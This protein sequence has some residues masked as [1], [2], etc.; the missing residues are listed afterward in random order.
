MR[1]RSS[2]F[3]PRRVVCFTRAHLMRWLITIVIAWTLAAATTCASSRRASSVEVSPD[4]IDNTVRMLAVAQVVVFLM[5]R[6]PDAAS[7]LDKYTHT[8]GA[9]PD[10][11]ALVHLRLAY[12]ARANSTCALTSVVL[13]VARV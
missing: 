10:V 1:D 8:V 2:C 4:N 9:L 3:Q 7:F 6:C 11:A 13:R 12:I 5:S